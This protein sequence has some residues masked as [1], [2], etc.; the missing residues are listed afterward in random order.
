[1]RRTILSILAAT[2][3][4]VVA[5]CR[6]QVPPPVNIPPGAAHT[7]ASPTPTPNP[8]VVENHALDMLR[9]T[10][11]MFYRVM[12]LP[13]KDFIVISPHRVRSTKLFGT[14]AFEL[15][16]E[17]GD[18]YIVRNLPPEDPDSMGH[19]SWMRQIK[20]EF[21]MQD[22]SKYFTDK[23]IITDLPDIYPPF[24]DRLEF[25]RK[26]A[27]LPT[28]GRW[29]MS[30][31]VADMNGDGRPDLVMPPQR[32]GYPFPSIWLQQP[33]HS[34]KPWQGLKFPDNIKLD[35]GSVRVADFDGDG[36]PDIAIACHFKTNYILYGNGKGDFT[37]YVELP[38]V[39]PSVTSRSLVVADF[40]HDGRPDVAIEDEVNLKVSTSEPL[41]S[42]LIEVLLNLPS[43]WKVVSDGFPKDIQGDWLSAADLDLD[44]YPD[45]LL[46][47]RAESVRDIVW[48]NVGKGEK[49]ANIA[50]LQM[51]DVGFILSNAVG[52]FDGFK[53]PDVVYCFEQ[54]N[55]KTSAPA[56][57]ACAIFHFHDAKG[58]FSETPTATL[59]VK[60]SVYNDNIVGVAAGDIDGDGR[61]D[62]ALIT[63]F[64]K[65]RVF[66]QFPDHRLYEEQSPEIDLGGATPF[67][68]KIAD[69]YG[70][71][72]GEVIISTVPNGK[73]QGGVFVFAPRPKTAA[74]AHP[75]GKRTGRK[76]PS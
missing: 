4:A 74:A 24:T 21:Y 13:K 12:R 23:Y 46:T 3:L 29:E 30:F 55:W 35:Y 70:D 53:Q 8:G 32:L 66:L 19:K 47:S 60:N 25:V 37:R 50:A 7:A 64:G 42:G 49:F 61:D 9:L 51:P 5:P 31:D 57:Q 48:H 34:W 27:G 36:H 72:R 26:D 18:D 15:V 52:H 76:R 75:P 10:R 38:R 63:A 68:V 40:N 54:F 69:L 17:E 39:N 58:A 2:C 14:R 71:G 1:M 45:L 11:R 16:G 28:A 59:F 44:G 65:V 56:A 33:D 6:A 43:G 22:R 20:Q 67:D 73:A 62:V 41:H